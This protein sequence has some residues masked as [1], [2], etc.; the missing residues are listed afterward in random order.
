M[1]DF[2]RTLRDG[3]HGLASEHVSKIERT[4]SVGA[5]VDNHKPLVEDLLQ[6]FAAGKYQRNSDLAHLNEANWVR[7]V[8]KAGPVPPSASGSGAVSSEDFARVVYTRVTR[9]F[10]TAALASRIKKFVP[11]MEQQRTSESILSK[12]SRPR[13]GQKQPYRIPGATGEAAWTGIDEPKRKQVIANAKRMQRM[14]FV[15][16][17]VDAAEKLLSIG[18]HSAT[19]VPLWGS[20]SSL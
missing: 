20:S 17:D 2:W 19:Q 12:Q 14:L 18:I 8:K 9:A 10:P 16:P 6:K 15:T 13:P 7:L 4:L 11:R 1:S 5:F 3:K